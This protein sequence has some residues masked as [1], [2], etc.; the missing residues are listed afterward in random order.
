MATN[1]KVEEARENLGIDE[2]LS[3][4]EE[5]DMVAGFLKAGEVFN[6]VVQPIEI[7]R[8]GTPLFK[9]NIHPYTQEQL[10]AAQNKATTKGKNP[11]GPKYPKIVTKYDSKVAESYLIYLCTT[12]EDKAKFWDNQ[13]F[14]DHYNVIEGYELIDKVLLPG[15][16]QYVMELL[17]TLGGYAGDDDEEEKTENDIDFAKNS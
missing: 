11:K 12:E 1:K 17:D 10:E 16:K 8:N 9:F 15:E 2:S 4:T 6:E 13:Q 14:K 5:F 3:Q 7:R